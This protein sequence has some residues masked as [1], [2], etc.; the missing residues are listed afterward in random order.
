MIVMIVAVTLG[1]WLGALL[2]SG[3]GTLMAILIAMISVIFAAQALP[4]Q[5]LNR[6][7]MLGVAAG[8]FAALI[9][10]SASGLQ[11]KIP[12]VQNAVPVLA[13]LAFSGFGV[14]IARQFPNYPSSTKKPE[15][16]KNLVL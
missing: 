10:L 5:W 7:L 8:V 13:T 12:L 9:G 15:Y 1:G 16:L 3:L 2:L 6:I 14:I 4:R 11:A